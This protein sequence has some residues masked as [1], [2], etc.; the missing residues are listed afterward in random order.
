MFGI[1]VV[2]SRIGTNRCRFR[3]ARSQWRDAIRFMVVT[4][5][6]VGATTEGDACVAPTFIPEGSPGAQW[7]HRGDYRRDFQSPAP[8][9]GEG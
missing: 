7:M 5:A 1:Y 8:P 6:D 4:D 2:G 3:C 9:A